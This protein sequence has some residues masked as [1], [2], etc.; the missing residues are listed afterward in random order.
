MFE[1]GEKVCVWVWAV[2][3]C[4]ACNYRSKVASVS[5][6]AVRSPLVK[7]MFGKCVSG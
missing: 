2:V 3:I 4:V 5:V 6:L 7:G 1:N